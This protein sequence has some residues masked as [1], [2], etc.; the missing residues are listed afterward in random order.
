MA[1]G[2]PVTRSQSARLPTPLPSEAGPTKEED[3]LDGGA[4]FLSGR[5]ESLPSASRS[6]TAER[7]GPSEQAVP[8]EQA[9]PVDNATVLD[10]VQSLGKALTDY[11]LRVDIIEE[12]MHQLRCS[13]SAPVA[14]V[15]VTPPG[16]V[17]STP[18]DPS[19]LTCRADPGRSAA[20][21]RPH[22]ACPGRACPDAVGDIRRFAKPGEF[23]GSGS[24]ESFIAQFNVIASA[25]HWSVSERLALLVASLKGSALE[26]FARLPEHQR[27]DFTHLSKALEDRFGVAHQE[28]WFRSQLRRRRREAGETLP[29]LA[30]EIERLVSLAYPSASVDLRDSLTCDHFLD[31]LGDAELHIAVRQSRPSTL[32]QA[33]ASAV[34]IESVRRAAGLNSLP[35]VSG[36]LIRQSH[37]PQGQADSNERADQAEPPTKQMF[38]E[39]LRALHVLQKSLRESARSANTSRSSAAGRQPTGACWE[40]GM[41]GHFRR[42]CPRTRNQTSAGPTAGQGNEQ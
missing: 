2:G 5:G 4:V 40:C 18:G 28:P 23:D 36:A 34:E 15:V 30:Q 29:H 33:L 27:T 14:G 38:S 26:L 39:I 25:Q 1:D 35:A 9:G 6:G 3:M 16:A 19:R 31:A 41:V 7:V 37:T 11:S 17:G 8:G 32:P 20:G 10:A 21:D 13:V 42:Q 12:Q 22:P 24:W